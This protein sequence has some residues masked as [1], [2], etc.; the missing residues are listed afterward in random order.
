MKPT[1]RSGLKYFAVISAVLVIGG[2]GAWLFTGEAHER[3][4]FIEQ[5]DP[6]SGYRCRF[7]VA[8]DYQQREDVVQGTSI[9]TTKPPDPKWYYLQTKILR[10]P[11]PETPVI[12]LK[13]FSEKDASLVPIRNG[14]P[15]PVMD[16]SDQI[17]AVRHFQIDL[18]CP[19]TVVTYIENGKDRSNR[20]ID[21]YVSLPSG[22]NVYRLSGHISEGNPF[23]SD[24]KIVLK[25]NVAALDRE[26]EAILSSFHVEKIV[27]PAGGK[28]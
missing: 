15:A 24:Y 21:M 25:R 26:M 28:R 20:C 8:S 13:H 12:S 16:V 17:L 6:A 18:G 11:P 1:R 7:T 22:R 14:Y 5:S 3:Q 2:G 23:V 27:V 4:E 9:F 19:V 10:H